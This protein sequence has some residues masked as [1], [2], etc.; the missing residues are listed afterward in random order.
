[1]LITGKGVTTYLALSNK[2]SNNKQKARFYITAI[3]NQDFRK[4]LKKF[5]NSPYLGYKS[6]QFHNEPTKD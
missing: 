1:M 2:K 6:K 5:D 3:T 4:F